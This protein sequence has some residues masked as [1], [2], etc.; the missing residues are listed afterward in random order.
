M[1]RPSKFNGQVLR[2]TSAWLLLFAW[3]SVSAYSQVSS[4]ADAEPTRILF[5]FDASNSMN[6]MWGKHR[7][8]ETATDLLSQTLRELNQNDKLE[9]GLRVYGHGTKHVIG[10]QNCED[11][12]LIVPL[13]TDNKLLIKQSLNRLQAQGTTPIARSL[14]QAAYDFPE[15]PGRNVIVLITDGIEACDEDPCAV[16]RALQSKGIV[17]KPFIIGLGIDESMMSSLECIGNFYDATDPVAFEEVLRLV[18]EQALHNTTLHIELH[19]EAGEPTVTN[20]P[21]T[22]TDI[23]TG[24]RHPQ[25]IHTKRPG[26]FHDTVYVDPIPTYQLTLHS[27]PQEVLD[28]VRLQPGVHNVIAVPNMG[29]G[30]VKPQFSR[31]NNNPYGGFDVSWH[32][33]GECE[34]FFTSPFG[35]DI[36][37]RSGTYDLFLPVKPPMWIRE[38]KI[39]ENKLS[40]VVVPAPGYLSID[41][42]NYG[43]VTILQNQSLATVASWEPLSATKHLILQPG[44]Y[45]LL[46]RA[47]RARSTLYTI[48]KQFSITSGTKTNIN[49]NG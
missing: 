1:P 30:T 16:S 43:H 42:L 45:T 10:Q 33:P 6:A 2:P 44:D 38:V 8:F 47:S 28:S 17:V 23:R 18:L 14:E 25:W 20:V 12:E 9:L 19:D 4:T 3:V 37:L 31:G 35:D 48:K 22:F 5:V 49:I 26:G 27:L 24:V 15:S 36:T 32:V 39:E 34:P 46:F 29:Q 21:Y 13:G 40:D 7:K 11:T 41:G